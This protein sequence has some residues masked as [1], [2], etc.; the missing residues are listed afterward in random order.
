M[1]GSILDYQFKSISIKVVKWDSLPI[2][3]QLMAYWKVALVCLCAFWVSTVIPCQA[4][5][6]KAAGESASESASQSISQAGWALGDAV[7]LK[8]RVSLQRTLHWPL[9]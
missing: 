9:D 1:K 2:N 7:S 3:R 8:K 5:Q 6:Q 4:Q